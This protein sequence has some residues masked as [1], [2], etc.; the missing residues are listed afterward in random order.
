MLLSSCGAQAQ[1]Q[2]QPQAAAAQCQPN[3]TP[4][5]VSLKESFRY[6]TGNPYAP[7]MRDGTH[8]Y[9]FIEGC[10]N[11]SRL[12]G[13]AT[14]G[15]EDDANYQSVVPVAH[16]EWVRTRDFTGYIE[17]QKNISHGSWNEVKSDDGRITASGNFYYNRDINYQVDGANIPATFIR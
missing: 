15:V 13:T 6:G 14:T 4:I 10:Q 8:R 7:N 17:E 1:V 3:E 2:T 16:P 11:G 9:L 5:R 12:R